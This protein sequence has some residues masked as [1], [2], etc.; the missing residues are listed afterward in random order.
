MLFIVEDIIPIT[1]PLVTVAPE[2]SISEAW[3]LMIDRE[4]SQL[5]V[6]D[7]DNRTRGFAITEGAILRAVQ[8]FRTLPEN[9]L[10]RDVMVSA[11]RVRF[12]TN[13]LDVLDEIQRESFVL[14]VD[15]DD[16]LRAIVTTYDTTAHFQRYAEDIML[17][18]DIEATLKEFISTLYTEADLK[19]AISETAL[20]TKELR[21]QL[22]RGVS[23][24]LTKAGIT[25]HSFDVAVV[26]AVIAD[27]TADKPAKE[28]D[29]LTFQEY[30]DILL[31]SPSCPKLQ[32][33]GLLHLCSDAI[34]EPAVPGLNHSSCK[35]HQCRVCEV[36][37]GVRRHRILAY[38]GHTGKMASRHVVRLCK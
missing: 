1:R 4:Y 10:V 19:Q 27:F 14:V 12:D 34:G 22:K 2:A 21:R 6:V 7:A 30:A 20:H 13:L 24:Y 26:E 25:G 29:R 37:G 38:L 31:Q 32:N 3:D 28:F 35:G 9:L 23:V 17:V 36:G 8:N 5:P 16:K 11:E 15:A 18:E 33:A